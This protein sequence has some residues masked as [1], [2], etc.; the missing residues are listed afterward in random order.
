MISFSII[1]ILVKYCNCNLLF[2]YS[3]CWV[4]HDQHKQANPRKCVKTT[5]VLISQDQP[6]IQTLWCLI[7]ASSRIG[8]H[9]I[10]M[11]NEDK[12]K[13]AFHGLKPYARMRNRD[14]S[15]AYRIRKRWRRG[16]ECNVWWVIESREGENYN[17]KLWRR[18]HGEDRNGRQAIGM[19]IRSLVGAHGSWS[20]LWVGQTEKGWDLII[21]NLYKP[22]EQSFKVIL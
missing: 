3:N 12:G 13:A 1:F 5:E 7:G 18:Q 20:I 8:L 19:V 9:A 21:I 16:N 6:R 11:R 15:K 17:T 14:I 4:C 22:C 10:V 2:Q